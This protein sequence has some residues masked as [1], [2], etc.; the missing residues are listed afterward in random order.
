MMHKETNA[1]VRTPCGDTD[2][3]RANVGLHQGS[4][5]NPFLFF[6]VMDT[7]TS[8][9]REEEPQ[10][11]WELLFADDIYIYGENRRGVAK[12]IP[13]LEG[14][15]GTRWITG[16]RDLGLEKEGGDFAGEDGDA[17]GCTVHRIIK[18][19]LHDIRTWS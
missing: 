4:A 7:L 8:E 13:S 1:L 5:L 12:K 6:I 11:L 18:S 16:G 17:N 3:F 2:P 10:D 9:L 15:N 14:E 19:D